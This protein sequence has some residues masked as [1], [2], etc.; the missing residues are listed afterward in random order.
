MV[1]R[2]QHYTI[3]AVLV[4]SEEISKQM[5][6]FVAGV[7]KESIID[8]FGTVKKVETPIV[9][10]SQQ[11]V[12]LHVEKFWV[13]S[14]AAQRLPLQIEDAARP[15]TEGDPLSHVNLDTR[16]DNRVLDLRTPTSQAIYRLQVSFKISPFYLKLK[17]NG[18]FV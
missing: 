17:L 12:E 6:K 15:N 4:V 1:I 13:V 14:T 5:V 10:C 7:P 3:Q 2:Q 9:S 18:F 11:T 8:V 16:L